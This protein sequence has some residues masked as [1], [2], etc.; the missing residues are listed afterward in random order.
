MISVSALCSYSYCQ[1]KFYLQYA[2]KIYVPFPK[3]SM[4]KG[5]VRHE[6]EEYAIKG[7]ERI[8]KH[9]TLDTLDTLE[10]QFHSLYKELFTGAIERHKKTLEE[11]GVNIEEFETKA[12][13]QMVATAKF[14]IKQIKDFA[15]K[16]RLEK[17]ELFKQL[18][19]KISPEVKIDTQFLQLRGIIDQVE[20]HKDY[21]LP[22]E[23]K[24]G[25][26][27][28]EGVW[29]SHKIQAAAYMMMLNEVHGQKLAQKAVVRYLDAGEE[30]EVIL[31][32][33]LEMEIKNLVRDT[34]NLRET[35]ELPDFVENKNKCNSCQLKEHCYNDEFMKEKMN[36]KWKGKEI[37]NQGD[38]S[39]LRK[40]F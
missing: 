30:R 9:L 5:T 37:S 22:I 16:H 18:I 17:E 3:D 28:K 20:D 13:P 26:I 7:Q 34:N 6:V 8:I 24:T 35:P 36:K 39:D 11:T 2:L 1:R 38:N 23:L 10:K 29:P 4:I 12:Y 40:F 25:S 14:R 19:P 32:P 31:N 21:L 15:L 27:P 33:F